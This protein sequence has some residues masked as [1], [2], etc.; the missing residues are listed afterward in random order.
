MLFGKRKSRD[1][2]ERELR[3]RTEAWYLKEGKGVLDERLYFL[4]ECGLDRVYLS[5]L[6]LLPQGTTYKDL[7]PLLKW[8]HRFISDRDGDDILVLFS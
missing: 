8:E 2:R 4:R 1:R 3:L 7:D 5:N 6:D